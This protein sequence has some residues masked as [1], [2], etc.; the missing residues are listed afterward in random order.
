MDLPRQDLH[1]LSPWLNA[2]G[3]LGFSPR[4]SWPW[5][6]PQGAFVTNPVSRRLRHPAE[7]PLALDY[8]AGVLLHSGYPNPG[9]H[10]VI[11]QHARRWAESGQP[12][13]VHLLAEEPAGLNEMVRRLEGLE[14]VAAL[15]L[16]LPP[17]AGRDEIA[18][19]LEAARGE[20]PLVVCIGLN[21]VGE[22]WV[23]RLPKQGASAVVISAPRGALPAAGKKAAHGRLYGPALFPLAL[24]AVE[25]LGP[26]GLPVIAGCG[27]FD[28]AAGQALLDA[29]AWAVQVDVA[30]WQLRG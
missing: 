27:V 23:T 5:P 4:Q 10:G 18:A 16:G 21:R 1:V 2:P 28:R 25:R 24:E 26:L 20:L 29:G 30:L 11:K 14:G 9:F 12:V 8:P 15:E 6:E 17:D 3:L 7:Q 19:L 22:A 13:W